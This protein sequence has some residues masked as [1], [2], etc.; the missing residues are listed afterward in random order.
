MVGKE[1]PSS[2]SRAIETPTQGRSV[3]AAATR[4]GTRP[5]IVSL[6]RTTGNRAV[7]ELL[8]AGDGNQSQIPVLQRYVLQHVAYKGNEYSASAV[9]LRAA[10]SQGLKNVATIKVTTRDAI[11]KESIPPGK[12]GVTPKHSEQVCWEAVKPDVENVGNPAKIQWLYTEREPCGQAQGQRNCR[13][14]LDG[15]LNLHGAHGAF[16]PVYYSFNYPDNRELEAA[17]KA[18]FSQG[19]VANTDEAYE[20]AADAWLGEHAETKQQISEAQLGF[21]QPGP[22][23]ASQFL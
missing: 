21:S 19:V 20:A 18:L 14:F 12:K 3:R 17:A 2:A 9:A 6:Q 5:D 15:L 16:T 1:R 23:G 11:T 10:E 13:H 4:P 7:C 22:W 8:G